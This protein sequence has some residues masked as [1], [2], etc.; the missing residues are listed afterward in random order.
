MHAPLI[1]QGLCGSLFLIQS[2][3]HDLSDGQITREVECVRPSKQHTRWRLICG[4]HL[5]GRHIA[6]PSRMWALAVSGEGCETQ[7]ALWTGGSRTRHPCLARSPGT[8]EVGW[9]ARGHDIDRK[10]MAALCLPC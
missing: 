3:A 2:I 1:C 9:C 7:S 10:K 4:G 5:F 6:T 8:I